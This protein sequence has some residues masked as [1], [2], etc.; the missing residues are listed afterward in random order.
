MGWRRLPR[1]ERANGGPV[2]TEGDIVD[3]ATEPELRKG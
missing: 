2:D 3:A 1:I